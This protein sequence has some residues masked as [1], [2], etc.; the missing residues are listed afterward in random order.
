MLSNYREVSPGLVR[1]F[2][3]AETVPAGTAVAVLVSITHG[4]TVHETLW[5][6]HIHQHHP[7][8]WEWLL[9]RLRTRRVGGPLS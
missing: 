3:P 5:G 2:F 7:D 6:W 4:W 8:G 9:E 1:E